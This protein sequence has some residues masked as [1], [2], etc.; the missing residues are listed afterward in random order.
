MKE[1]ED[2]SP[3]E[4][5]E[6]IRDAQKAKAE[7]DKK[8]REKAKSEINAVLKEYGLKLEEL[9]PRYGTSKTETAVPGDVVYRDPSNPSNTWTGKGRKPGWLKEREAAGANIEDFRV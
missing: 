5:D 2:M 1:L 8:Q 6:L 4:L 3:A 9:F 7:H